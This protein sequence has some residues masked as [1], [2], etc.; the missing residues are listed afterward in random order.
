MT[1][2]TQHPFDNLTPDFIMD[3][4]ESCGYV[5]DSGF[6]DC[7]GAVANGCESQLRDLANCGA[8]GAACTPR[9]A[10][11]SCVTGTCTVVACSGSFADCNASVADGCEAN[12]QTDVA[13]CGACGSTCPI[14]PANAVPSCASGRCRITCEPGFEDCNGLIDDGCEANLADSG[15]TPAS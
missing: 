3:A 6:R 8:C 4:V 13:N 5:C 11:A 12:T 1:T 15:T 14:E 2:D 10:V 7:D 9:N